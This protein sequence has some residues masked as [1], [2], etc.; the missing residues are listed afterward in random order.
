MLGTPRVWYGLIGAVAIVAVVAAVVSVSGTG[1][2]V[3]RARVQPSPS[4]AAGPNRQQCRRV[5]MVVVEQSRN[6][7]DEAERAGNGHDSA[8]SDLHRT[9]GKIK[10]ALTQHRGRVTSHRLITAGDSVVE[11]VDQGRDALDGR[12][13][14]EKA[15]RFDDAL[16]DL[17]DDYTHY[18]R[19]CRSLGGDN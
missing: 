9:L 11:D 10:D 13:T 4:S 8:F 12:V 14:G 5:R 19:V 1:T 17:S 16:T 7:A 3:Q 15:K 6:I 18:E 2:G